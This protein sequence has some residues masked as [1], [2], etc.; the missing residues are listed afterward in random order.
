MTQCVACCQTCGSAGRWPALYRGRCILCRGMLP[1][2][3]QEEASVL[4]SAIRSIWAAR[5]VL[6]LPEDQ[7][8]ARTMMMVGTNEGRDVPIAADGPVDPWTEVLATWLASKPEQ[9]TME[10]ALRTL[11]F[12]RT[13]SRRIISRVANI[14]SSL[15]YATARRRRRFLAAPLYFDQVKAYVAMQPPPVAQVIVEDF[16]EHLGVTKCRREEVLIGLAFTFLG[17]TRVRTHRGERRVTAYRPP[18]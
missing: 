10:E 1:Q 15:G 4:V 3:L 8:G 7:V 17:W 13:P 11:G 6:L 18:E 9:V 2:V 14:L 12:A 5:G 16:M